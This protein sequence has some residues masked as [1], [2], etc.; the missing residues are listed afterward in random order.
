M[1]HSG[2]AFVV[3]VVLVGLYAVRANVAS[4]V[5]ALLSILL[6]H[7]GALKPCKHFNMSSMLM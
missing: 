3:S 6:K 5:E 7:K 1:M 2:I 4:K